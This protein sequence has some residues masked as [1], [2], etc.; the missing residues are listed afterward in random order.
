M[1]RRRGELGLSQVEL[2]KI[3]GIKSATIA[4]IEAGRVSR[5]PRLDTLEGL[6]KGLRVDTGVL[7]AL[8]RGEQQKPRLDAEAV[9]PAQ[10]EALD[11]LKELDS[12]EFDLAIR[13]LR[14]LK[15]K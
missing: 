14:R 13:M 15:G 8:V 1:V 10:R 4:A 5:N 2:A 7:I 12:E 3:A 9:T 11:I 6:A